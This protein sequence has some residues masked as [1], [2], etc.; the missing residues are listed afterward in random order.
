MQCIT[1]LIDCILGQRSILGL[2]YIPRKGKYQNLRVLGFGH[3]SSSSSISSSSCHS[4]RITHK[5]VENITL[6]LLG[7][8]KSIISLFPCLQTTLSLYTAVCSCPGSTRKQF[9][10][11]LPLHMH[12]Y[13]WA[14]L[15]LRLAQTGNF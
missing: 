1:G 15:C 7:I 14:S 6:T 3:K 2:Q 13:I 5:S 8:N 10:T 4:T 9:L 12:P 11:G